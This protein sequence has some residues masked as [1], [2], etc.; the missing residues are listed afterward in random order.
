MDAPKE[1]VRL[2]DQ[3]GGEVKASHIIDS[4]M[5][6]SLIEHTHL[7]REEVISSVETRLKCFC[8]SAGAKPD[9]IKTEL[10]VGHSVKE[11]GNLCEE[12]SPDLVVLGA[13]GESCAS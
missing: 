2:A 13:W 12:F 6:E 9:R 11:F 10:R 8:E 5:I 7:S 1:A 4:E 3:Q